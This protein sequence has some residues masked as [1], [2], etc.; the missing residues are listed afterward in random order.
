MGYATAEASAAVERA[1]AHVGADDGIEAWIRAALR[2]GRI[3]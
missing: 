2:E 1:R 3:T